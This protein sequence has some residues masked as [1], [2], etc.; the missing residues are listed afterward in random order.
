MTSSCPEQK[1]SKQ[2]AQ[3]AFEIVTTFPI[4]TVKYWDGEGELSLYVDVRIPR[5]TRLADSAITSLD[6]KAVGQ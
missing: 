5:I 2:R 3:V 6:S 1:K 4:V